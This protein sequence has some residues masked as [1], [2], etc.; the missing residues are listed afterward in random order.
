MVAVVTAAGA[1][2]VM[3]GVSP[4]HPLLM[5]SMV[6]KAVVTGGAGRF[7][8]LVLLVRDRNRKEARVCRL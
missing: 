4:R 2:A 7:R 3:N 8:V 5:I 6:M 1:A